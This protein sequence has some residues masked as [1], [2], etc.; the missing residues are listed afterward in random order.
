MQ[1]ELKCANKNGVYA[2]F[3]LDFASIFNLYSLKNIKN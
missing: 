1:T 2:P 3:Y